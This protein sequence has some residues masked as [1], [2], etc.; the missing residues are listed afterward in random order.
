MLKVSVIRLHLSIARH[1]S[2]Y[3]HSTKIKKLVKKE[4]RCAANIDSSSESCRY[5]EHYRYL[6]IRDLYLNPRK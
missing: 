3:Y 2:F 5:L 1:S 6:C 4:E